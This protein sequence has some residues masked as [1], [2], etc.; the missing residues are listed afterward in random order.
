[1]HIKKF[2][3]FITD[4]FATDEDKMVNH[5][6]K[7]IDKVDR[8]YSDY[9]RMNFYF[10]NVFYQVSD[11]GRLYFE[12]DGDKESIT[13]K[14]CVT[15]YNKLKKIKN[16]QEQAKYKKQEE[17]KIKA[18]R[19]KYEKF[20]EEN[21]LE[22]M[23]REL[24]EKNKNNDPD[25]LTNS[26]YVIYH[27]DKD[28]N[29]YDNII[30]CNDNGFTSKSKKFLID[31][32]NNT[33]QIKFGRH[34]D[35]NYFNAKSKDV[36]LVNKLKYIKEE[37]LDNMRTDKMKREESKKR[38]LKSFRESYEKNID[39]EVVMQ[40]QNDLKSIDD[41]KKKVK[42][43]HVC[44]PIKSFGSMGDIIEF[45]HPE[46]GT[47]LGQYDKTGKHTYIRTNSVFKES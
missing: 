4:L 46:T 15:L 23:I 44:D 38:F 13:S 20:K 39:K 6:I 28:S 11:M 42:E 9:P 22:S 3:N 2:E 47:K 43:I 17:D 40:K 7:N 32:K 29:W 18:L 26:G 24:Y 12:I 10:N 19:T 25:I 8:I 5:I 36:E 34:Y 14:K 16:D 21:D 45:E 27:E 33:I 30:I 35:T 41:F 31:Y 37:V 1:M